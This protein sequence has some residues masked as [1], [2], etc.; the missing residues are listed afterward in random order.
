M[1]IKILSKVYDIQFEDPGLWS[2]NGMG[3][4]YVPD[5]VIRINSSMNIETQK[6]TLIHEIL[7]VVSDCCGLDLTEQQINSLETGLYSVIKD[8][9]N[10]DMEI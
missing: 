1:K 9:K 10:F 2:S 7:H 3:R 6:S 5:Q 4:C 8:N